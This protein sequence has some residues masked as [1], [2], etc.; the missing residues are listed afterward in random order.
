MR[1]D[2]LSVVWILY[3]TFYNHSTTLTTLYC[4]ITL[5]FIFFQNG[6]SSSLWVQAKVKLRFSFSRSG[7]F[8]LEPQMSFTWLRRH[9]MSLSDK[10]NLNWKFNCVK[11]S[12]GD[13]KGFF[14]DLWAIAQSM[15][16]VDF[17]TCS[18]RFFFCDIIMLA[19]K[20]MITLRIIFREHF[21]IL[22]ISARFFAHHYPC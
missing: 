5:K 10:Y 8:G 15:T 1:Y 18:F 20:K 21:E 11:I 2:P 9:R 4:F 3:L 16:S 19:L 17:L 22:A 13:M 6:R 12:R 14:F 7:F